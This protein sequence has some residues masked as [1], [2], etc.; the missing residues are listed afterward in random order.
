MSHQTK[1][2]VN[3]VDSPYSCYA[4]VYLK[5]SVKNERFSSSKKSR[6][7]KTKDLLESQ[8]VFVDNFNKILEWQPVRL[9]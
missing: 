9:K 2:F 8:S 4:D 5:R 1:S 6:K 3:V 7:R